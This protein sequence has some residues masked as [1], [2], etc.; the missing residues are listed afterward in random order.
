MVVS[1]W[2]YLQIPQLDVS[3]PNWRGHAASQREFN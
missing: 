1:Q 2:T 3:S